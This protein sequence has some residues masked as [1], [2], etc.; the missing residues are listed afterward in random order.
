MLNFFKPKPGRFGVEPVLLTSGRINTGTLAAGTQTHTIG[1]HPAK[2]YINRVTVSAGTFPAATTNTIKL[3]RYDAAAATA[4]DITAT[5]DVNNKTARTSLAATIATTATDSI[6]TLRPG[7]TLEVVL[8]T[9]GTV[10]TQP[11]DLVV[12]VE[13][14]PLE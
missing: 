11:D 7:D 4:R 3:V 2:S 1:N 14:L 13:L 9:T 6:R 8:V 12:N 10:T 5:L